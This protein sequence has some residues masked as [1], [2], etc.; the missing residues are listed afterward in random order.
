[1]LVLVVVISRTTRSKCYGRNRS[2]LVIGI[3]VEVTVEVVLVKSSS[4]SSSSS[5]SL[6]SRRPFILCLAWKSK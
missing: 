5:S 4:S 2:M 1:M 3:V 6:L